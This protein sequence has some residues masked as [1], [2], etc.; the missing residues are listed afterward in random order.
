VAVSKSEA[1]RLAKDGLEMGAHVLRG[2]LRMGPAGVTVNEIDITEWLARHADS[3]LILIA[4]PI[5]KTAADYEIKSCRRCG[6]D[7]EGDTCPHCAEA[8]ARLRG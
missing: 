3:E 8:R 1:R 4:V 6:R 7:Y 2:V 5:G